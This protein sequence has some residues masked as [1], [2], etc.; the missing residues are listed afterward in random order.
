M[1]SSPEISRGASVTTTTV[2]EAKNVATPDEVRPFADKGQAEVVNIAGKEL[3][4]GTFEPGWKWSEHIKPIAQTDSC[5]APHFGFC[6]S[7]RMTIRMDDGSET[8]VKAGDFVSI[9]PGH[10][11]W[12]EGDEACVFIDFGS[13]GGYAKSG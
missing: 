13:I 3:L 9:P 2:I 5:Q 8:E 1:V 7:G 12:V 6:Q 11:A 4:R 10:D